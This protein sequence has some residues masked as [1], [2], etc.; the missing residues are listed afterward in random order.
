MPELTGRHAAIRAA[1]AADLAHVRTVWREFC[2]TCMAFICG[3]AVVQYSSDGE[4]P[5]AFNPFHHTLPA[6]I[7][8]TRPAAVL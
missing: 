5:D 2:P 6:C 1:C 3:R 8:W 4:R 7:G